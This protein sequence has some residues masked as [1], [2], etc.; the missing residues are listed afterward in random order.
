MSFPLVALMLVGANAI[1]RVSLITGVV[2]LGA[3]VAVTVGLVAFGKNTTDPD[4]IPSPSWLFAAAALVP[5][6]S[7]TLI[8]IRPIQDW[9]FPAILIIPAGLGAL[10]LLITLPD[11][12]VA[13]LTFPQWRAV[14]W[15][16]V[17]IPFVGAS[18]VLGLGESDMYLGASAGVSSVGRVL[19]LVLAA[20]VISI[21]F[22]GLIQGPA[23]SMMGRA[24]VP[25]VALVFASTF[26]ASWAGLAFLLMFGLVLGM[27]RA[28]FSTIWPGFI[29]TVA[30]FMGLIA[31]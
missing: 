29:A 2:A 1:W 30:L 3:A 20:L 6:I 5:T 27:L 14:A 8:T 15:S 9:I 4:T 22:Y 19:V 18:I 11:S 26:A 24:A 7:L 23:E 25:W 31:S 28:R 10:W 16:L 17:A 21:L 13:G 12:R